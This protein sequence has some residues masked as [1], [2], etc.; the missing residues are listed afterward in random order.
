[1]LKVIAIM[2]LKT[3]LEKNW[4]GYILSDIFFIHKRTFLWQ[5]NLLPQKHLGEKF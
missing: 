5:Q 2:N 1:M 4:N 3:P